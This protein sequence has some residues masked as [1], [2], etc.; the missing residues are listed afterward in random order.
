[1]ICENCKHEIDEEVKVCPYCGVIVRAESYPHNLNV[2]VEQPV[3]NQVIAEEHKDKLVKKSR[4]KILGVIS[5]IFFS[6]S[7]GTFFLANTI[8]N[9]ETKKPIEIPVPEP[10]IKVEEPE[11][12]HT[13]I[14]KGYEVSY[15][16]DY[17]A[18]IEEGLLLFENKD[19]YFQLTL[20]P[21]VN[22]EQF[23]QNKAALKQIL[24]SNGYIIESEEQTIRGGIEFYLIKIYNILDNERVDYEYFLTV[25]NNVLYEIMVLEMRKG[26]Y[27]KVSN[28]LRTIVKETKIAN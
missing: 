2:V 15:L 22:Q 14:Y 5:V 1:M 25:E 18:T 6:L 4:N 23:E 27:T 7:L 20:H 26:S 3:V 12:T 11:K 8:P 24:L 10:T 9:E 28:Q 13:I 19:L 16:S 21:N 17:E